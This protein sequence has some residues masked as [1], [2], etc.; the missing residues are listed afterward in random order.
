VALTG[1][2]TGSGEA[3]IRVRGRA[4]GKRIE[5][6]IRARLE[7]AGDHREALAK[8]W[9]RSHIASLH[10]RMVISPP[11]IEFKQAITDTALRYG[12]VSS[13]TSFVA[14]DSTRRTEGSHGTTVQVP[15]PVP[16]GV[17]YETTVEEAK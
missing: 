5:V 15:V 10:N 9:A 14:V 3:T 13:F 6:A 16:K 1:R 17:K 11:S 2:F 4:A 12:L 7:E 8:I